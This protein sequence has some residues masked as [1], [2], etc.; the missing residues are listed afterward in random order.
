MKSLGIN[1]HLLGF[2]RNLKYER[3]YKENPKFSLTTT[4]S[5]HHDPDN[6]SLNQKLL[7]RSSKRVI[8]DKITLQTQV[9]STHEFILLM[10]ALV[11]D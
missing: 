3:L 2:K 1:L 7:L 8:L 5:L 11:E 9:A 6:P 4:P 10:K